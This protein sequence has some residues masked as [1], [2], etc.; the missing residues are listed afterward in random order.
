MALVGL[1]D[2]AK[3]TGRNQT[4][5]HRAMK[6]GRLCYTADETGARRIDTAELDR[7][8]GIKH[9]NGASDDAM[10]QGVQSH[11]APVHEVVLLNRL[12]DDREATIRDLRARLDASE[13]ERRRLT[14]LLSPPTSPAPDQ[15]RPLGRRI[16]DWLVRQHV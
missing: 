5:I 6:T 12:L 4:T 3:L 13:D 7:V 9:T 8:F 14:L 1:S 10:A 15:P 2:A 11:V 16:L